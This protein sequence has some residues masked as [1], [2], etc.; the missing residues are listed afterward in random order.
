MKQL[1]NT[2]ASIL[3]VLSG[4]FSLYGQE[5]SFTSE[6]EVGETLRI[7]IVA[8]GEVTP[9]E[10]LELSNHFGEW[11]T[12]KK[13]AEKMILKGDISLFYCFNNKMTSLDVSQCTN[14]VKLN[15]D[16]NQLSSL[17]IKGAS[18]LEKLSCYK[19][20]LSELDLSASPA[21][22]N[23]DCFENQ[24]EKLDLSACEKLKILA[25]YK[26]KLKALDVQKQTALI[27]LMFDENEI[28][29]L[30]LSKLSLLK[31]F[32]GNK[33]KLTALDFSA[34]PALNTMECSHNQIEV[35]NVAKCA[36]LTQIFCADNKIKELDTK[37]CPQ[38]LLL[39]C[40]KNQLTKLDVS[41]NTKLTNLEC[42][43][44][45]IESINVENCSLLSD[46]NCCVNKITGKEMT[47]IVTALANRKEQK[48]GEFYVIDPENDMEKNVCLD[49]DVAILKEK[50]WRVLEK[51]GDDWL[52]YPG[53]K[54]VAVEEVEGLH[55]SLYPNPA[56]DRVHISG[57][58]KGGKVIF[59]DMQGRIAVI[60]QAK[61]SGVIDF[62]TSALANGL[63]LVKYGAKVTRLQVEHK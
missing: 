5:L 11:Y 24:L 34:C 8:T 63:Y 6:K 18:K 58:E 53:S 3:F 15:C 55:F 44:N 2:I 43:N 62:N 60:L 50:N 1:T 30:D 45:Q 52:D 38:L 16:R 37:D 48:E 7:R 61:D 54:K 22:T 9:V 36:N 35:L 26:N 25:C 27:S 39:K 57:L 47:N 42:A 29:S 10:G 31:V 12:F 20:K 14:L 46:F 40:S 19:N 49:T 33:N 28:E 17:I 21:L 13:T 59:Y 32:S 51:K 41:K 56:V 23:L 4:C